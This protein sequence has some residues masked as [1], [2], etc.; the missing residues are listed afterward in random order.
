MIPNKSAMVIMF[1]IYCVCI[2]FLLVNF[3]L[4]INFHINFDTVSL[5]KV[6]TLEG[7]RRKLLRLLK[8]YLLQA[9]RHTELV[10]DEPDLVKVNDGQHLLTLLDRIERNTLTLHV[11]RFWDEGSITLGENLELHGR[12]VLLL[13]GSNDRLVKS[14]LQDGD[15]ELL[16]EPL[17]RVL[18]D[19][20]DNKLIELGH[21]L[22]KLDRVGIVGIKGEV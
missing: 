19:S 8:K 6:E 1:F 4:L 21:S 14:L 16:T 9:D 13:T 15:V 12:R 3:G 22:M 17:L 20:V 2:F 11:V 7:E 10:I 5:G 18:S